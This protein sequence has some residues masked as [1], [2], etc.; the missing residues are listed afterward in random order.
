MSPYATRRRAEQ[1]AAVVNGESTRG[2]YDDRY[3]DLLLLVGALRAVPEPVARP[4]F[5]A[6]LR[7]RLVA[8]AA[9]TP[10]TAAAEADRLRL[11]P[12]DPGRVRNPR[13]RRIGIALGGLALVGATATMA[14]VAQSALPGDTLYP[15]KR[16]IENAHAGISVGD[17]GKGSTV[18]ASASTRLSEIEALARDGRGEDHPAAV[19]DTL[20]DFTD[21][22]TE[23]A[24]LLLA[25]YADKGDPAD[26]TKVRTFTATSMSSLADLDGQLPE[27][28]EDEW[29][30][31]VTTLLR[32]DD[33]AKLSCP[34]CDGTDLTTITPTL[35]TLGTGF[36]T[37]T[38]PR[39]TSPTSC[40]R[41]W[42][43][44]RWMRPTCLPAA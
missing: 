43:C 30:H 14:V 39:S 23:A 29:V 3:D 27:S 44:R 28:A 32:I 35:P 22:A 6:D 41:P 15:L 33:Q 5:I 9:A 4:E 18:L 2:A 40:C 20:N 42:C 24:D 25:S 13:E 11:R 19:S 34:T 31:A 1:F 26:V 37:G 36:G 17:D 8:E 12:V 38:C 16:G 21:Q 10:L 7:S